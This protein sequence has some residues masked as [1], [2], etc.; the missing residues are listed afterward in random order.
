MLMEELIDYDIMLTCVVI[1]HL[2]IANRSC[3]LETLAT[4]TIA[5]EKI[6]TDNACIVH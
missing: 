3:L 1:G 5:I 6:P 2:D 4:F